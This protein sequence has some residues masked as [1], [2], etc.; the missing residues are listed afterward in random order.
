M[1]KD[2]CVEGKE[3]SAAGDYLYNGGEWREHDRT[4]FKVFSSIVFPGLSRSLETTE[5]LQSRVGA[6]GSHAGA[7]GKAVNP[8]NLPMPTQH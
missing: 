2:G 6:G 3:G 8:G 4:G 5:R 1:I 7:G